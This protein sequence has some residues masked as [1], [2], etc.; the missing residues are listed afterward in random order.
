MA[1]RLARR[2]AVFCALLLAAPLAAQTLSSGKTQRVGVLWPGDAP[3]PRSR[4]EWLEAGL[5][6]YGYVAGKT[7]TLELKHGPDAESLR[8]AAAELVRSRVDVIVSAGQVA[9]VSAQRSTSVVPIVALGT[10]HIAAGLA[11]T[12]ARPG[13]NLTGVTI[14]GPELSAKRL[15]LMKEMLPGMSR[16]AVLWYPGDKAE[17]KL[18]ED[19]ARSLSVQ[20]QLLEVRNR[21]DLATVFQSARQGRADAITVLPSPLLFSFHGSILEHAA[22]DRLPAIYQWKEAAEAGG[23]ASYGPSLSGMWQ[24]IGRMAGKVLKGASPATLPIEQASEFEFVINVR[25]ANALGITIPQRML[26]RADKVID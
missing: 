22:K 5:K 20:I 1:I 12:L 19:T 15:T 2:F 7:L 16:V 10:D 11:A 9:A 24:Q 25:A 14:R 3:I 8:G 18:I 13:K 6:E 26:I 23:L 4:V 21:A 17:L